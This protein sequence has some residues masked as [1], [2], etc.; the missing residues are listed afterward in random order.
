MEIYF[1]PMEGMTSPL[2]RRT[3]AAAFGG[4]DKYFSPFISTNEAISLNNKESEDVDHEQNRGLCLI[5]QIISN[6]AGQSAQY[7][8]LLSEKYGYDEV[9]INL[10]CPSGTVVSKGKGSGMLRD[11]DAMDAYLGSLKEELDKLSD[12]GVKIPKVSIKT[13]IGFYEPGEHIRITRILKAHPAYQVTVHPRTRKQMY[14]GQADMDAFA[15]MYDE[16]K[17]AGIGVVYNGD[18][19]RPEDHE[20]ITE[21]FTD[22]DGVMIGRGLLAD[23]SLARRIKGGK[24]ASASEYSD[25]ME[26]IL[27]GYIEKIG[28]EKFILAKMKDLCNFMKPVFSGNDKGFK[29]MCKADSVEAFRVSL[30]QYIKNS[31]MYEV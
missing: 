28:V 11:P 7:I 17:S 10:G 6:S 12:E 26:R 20:K 23:P 13:R 19:K 14:G 29:E 16:L 22:L 18:I 21:R 4:C 3:H 2:L 25:Y 24:E 8:K 15:Y 1:A 30:K 5:P 27:D 31:K 9:N